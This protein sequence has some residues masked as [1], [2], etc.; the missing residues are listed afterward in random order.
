MEKEDK[1]ARDNANK[2]HKAAEDLAKEEGKEEASPSGKAASHDLPPE[3]NPEAALD[4]M[5][6]NMSQK[7]SLDMSD[8][9][10][11]I[12]FDPYRGAMN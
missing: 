7:E 11:D 10:N 5:A 1:E 4:K 2:A 3:L 12:V 6:K 9:G 8:V